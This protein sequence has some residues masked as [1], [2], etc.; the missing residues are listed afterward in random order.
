M[1]DDQK[2]HKK[3]ILKLFNCSGAYQDSF[4]RPFESFSDAKK[5][6]KSL[7]AF[8]I[9]NLNYALLFTSTSLTNCI[10]GLANIIIGITTFD[11]SDLKHGGRNL[12]DGAMH[13]IS[14]LYYAASIIIDTLDT[15]VRLITHS[16]ATV[17][18][19]PSKIAELTSEYLPSSLK[20]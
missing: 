17:A 10:L 11:S 18:L 12:K 6:V 4:F 14:A 3:D 1:F 7:A 2:K 5:N 19:V 8:P 20:F 16:L 15:L 9:I 13:L